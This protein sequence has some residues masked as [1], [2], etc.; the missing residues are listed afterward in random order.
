MGVPLGPVFLLPCAVASIPK[1]PGTDW[2]SVASIPKVPGTDWESGTAS[3]WMAEP[4]MPRG[5]SV[6]HARPAGAVFS[7]R[8]RS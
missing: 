2:E 4:A 8:H 3:I 7:P 6:W 1:V 5:H